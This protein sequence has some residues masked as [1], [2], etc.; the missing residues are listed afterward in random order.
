MQLTRAALLIQR[1]WRQHRAK[2][3]HRELVKKENLSAL[4][5]Q[6]AFRA[7]LRRRVVVMARAC[8]AIQSV[9]RGHR[10]RV[11]VGIYK[12]YGVPAHVAEAAA[13]TIQVC[14]CV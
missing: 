13:E 1:K 10:A 8:T 3:A 14:F 11:K 6:R 4:C 7:H 2:A 12:Q 5:I 9:W